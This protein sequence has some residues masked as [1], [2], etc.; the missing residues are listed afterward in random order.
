MNLKDSKYQATFLKI[1]YIWGKSDIITAVEAAF[2]SRPPVYCQ[3]NVVLYPSFY[4]YLQELPRGKP[5]FVPQ[6]LYHSSCKSCRLISGLLELQMVI[7]MKMTCCH[8][9]RNSQEPARKCQASVSELRALLASTIAP[10]VVFRLSY[11]LYVL[12]RSP[13][14]LPRVNGLFTL[15]GNSLMN[16]SLCE[17][18]PG[19]SRPLTAPPHLAVLRSQSLELG[20]RAATARSSTSGL[21]VGGGEDPASR[22]PAVK[23]IEG[24]WA[25]EGPATRGGAGRRG[26]RWSRQPP[27][28]SRDPSL[29]TGKLPPALAAGAWRRGGLAGLAP[30][31]VLSLALCLSPYRAGGSSVAGGGVAVLSRPRKVAEARAA[32]GW[33]GGRLQQQRGDP[34]SCH[35]RPP[36]AARL[37]ALRPLG[38]HGALV[39]SL[40][41]CP[42]GHAGSSRRPWDRDS[43]RGCELELPEDAPGEAVVHSCALA[44]GRVP[45]SPCVESPGL[46]AAGLPAGGAPGGHAGLRRPHRVSMDSMP[47]LT[48]CTEDTV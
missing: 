11:T 38:G 26:G 36:P 17:V 48:V 18:F 6:K 37:R 21:G 22:V 5:V 41:L 44:A 20:L 15:S 9:Q 47:L 43:A 8:R 13:A 29:R 12:Q 24:K 4:P 35:L 33:S 14:V 19:A 45:V 42:Q 2:K 3:I 25:W 23:D 7:E 31:R 28:R 46:A 27:A 30:P 10:T 16:F 32:G 40:G 34:R 1:I 39:P